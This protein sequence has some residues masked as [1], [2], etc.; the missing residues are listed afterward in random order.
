MFRINAFGQRI[1]CNPYL[2]FV[3]PPEG[4]ENG[5]GGGG[6][7]DDLGFPKDTPLTDMTPEQQAAYW[8]NE[9]KKQQKRAEGF[10]DYEQLKADAAELARLK[11]ENAT[12]QEKAIEEARRDG[13]N[14]GAERY[15]KDAV[16]GRF[17][18]LTGKTEEEVATAFAHVDPKSFTDD[19]GAIDADK[20]KAFAEVFGTK[21]PSGNTPDPV[22]EAL[23]RQR[24]AGGGSGSSIAEKR[25]E[26][27]ESLTKSKA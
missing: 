27:R 4:T 18:A 20:L 14:I 13:E 9:A 10:S 11:A 22:A 12:E 7:P 8:R 23:A 21:T 2:R 6:N 3:D 16:Q 1:Y 24:A 25:K 19:K 17:Q 15:L 5:G 26:T